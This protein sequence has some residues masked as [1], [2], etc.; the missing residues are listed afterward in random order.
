MLIGPERN[1]TEAVLAAVDRHPSVEYRGFVPFAEKRDLYEWARAVVFNGV[2]EDFGIVPVEAVAAGASCLAREE[3]FPALFVD[4]RTGLFHDGSVAG[5]R[6]AVDRFERDPFPADHARAEQ[7]AR[8]RFTEELRRHLAG[9]Y[10]ASDRRFRV[11]TA[12]RCR[13]PVGRP[14]PDQ[15]GE[16][17]TT[18]VRRRSESVSSATK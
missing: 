1:D 16:F 14:R 7:F 3:G 12:S 9:R 18:T 8:E 4:E 2:A 13:D 10:R 6:A 15:T 5:I 11:Q 17:L